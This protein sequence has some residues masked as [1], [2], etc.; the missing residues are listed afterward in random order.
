MARAV[1]VEVQ[2]GGT[3]GIVVTLRDK[4]GAPVPS[5]SNWRARAEVRYTPRADSPLLWHWDTAEDSIVLVGGDD[6][7]AL[8]KMPDPEVS[9]NWVWRLAWFDL[10]TVDQ[11]GDPAGRPVR[12]LIRVIPAVTQVME[13]L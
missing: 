11:N 1:E 8:L 13:A 9:L 3:Q 10:A 7:H 4:T 12:G 2:A 6:S 5:F